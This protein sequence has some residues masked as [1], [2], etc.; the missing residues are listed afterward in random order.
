MKMTRLKKSLLLLLCMM[1]I[2]A[3]ALVTSG[4]NNSKDTG[5]DTSDASAQTTVTNTQGTN[6]LGQGQTEFAFTVVDAQGNEKSYTIRTDK[7]NVGEALTELG[8]ISGVQDTYGLY[9][10]TVDGITVDYDKDKKYWAFYVNGA[11]ATA[12]VD[13]TEI[14]PGASYAFK[15]E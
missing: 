11:Y 2:A 5:A 6:V 15:V 13:T 1:L 14:T 10:K 7:K 9:V 4:C 3:M 8:L 12:G